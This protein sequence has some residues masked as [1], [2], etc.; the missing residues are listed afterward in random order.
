MGK[1]SDTK[2]AMTIGQRKRMQGKMKKLRA[3]YET[4]KG[5][6]EKDEVL[7]KALRKNRHMNRNDFLLIPAVKRERKVSAPAHLK[8]EAKTDSKSAASKQEKKPIEKKAA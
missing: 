8:T 2:R 1:I 6:K 3:L 4:A 5:E 7:K